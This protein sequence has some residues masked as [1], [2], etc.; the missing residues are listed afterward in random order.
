[1]TSGVAGTLLAVYFV[2]TWEEEGR[3]DGS[4]REDDGV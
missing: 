2:R 1:M 4:T 3:R